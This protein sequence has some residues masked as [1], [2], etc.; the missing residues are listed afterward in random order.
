MQYIV[1]E[2]ACH[3]CGSGTHTIHGVFDNEEAAD[4]LA[5][6]IP[7]DSLNYFSNRVEVVEWNDE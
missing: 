5:G 2:I 6:S 3:E 7:N 4:K 1:I